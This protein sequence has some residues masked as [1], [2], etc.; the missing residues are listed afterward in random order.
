MSLV[1]IMQLKR[2]SKFTN[3]TLASLFVIRYH[4]EQLLLDILIKI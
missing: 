1:L 4:F 2:E 3:P